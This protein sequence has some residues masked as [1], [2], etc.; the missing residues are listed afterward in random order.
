M[1]RLPPA[2]INIDSVALPD[3][4]GVWGVVPG[5]GPV[6]AIIRHATE[7]WAGHAVMYVGNSQ[8]VQATWPKVILSPAPTSNVIWATGQP[9]TAGQHSNIA[10]YA[11]T[12]VGTRYDIMA[13]PALIAAIF[14]AALTKNLSH[15]FGNDKWWDCS[16]LVEE[17]DDMAGIPMF[18]SDISAHLVTPAML[19]DLGV[20]KGWFQ[21]Q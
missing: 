16:G 2:G 9:A 6:A 19:M 17:C 3:S 14:D 7:S 8:I 4:P 12:L 20:R 5:V 13:Y 1:T 10:S 18:P 15:L 21:G 11:K